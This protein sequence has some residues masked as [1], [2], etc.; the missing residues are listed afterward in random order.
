M[1]LKTFFF[2]FLSNGVTVIVFLVSASLSVKINYKQ[3]ALLSERPSYISNTLLM[4]VVEKMLVLYPTMLCL[5]TRMYL[6]SLSVSVVVS[7]EISGKCYFWR[8]P[9]KFQIYYYYNLKLA[10]PNR[11]NLI[12]VSVVITVEINEVLLLESSV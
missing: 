6:C 8:L 12:L 2:F 3:D 5:R 11:V 4:I 9:H 7:V 10:R 1:Q